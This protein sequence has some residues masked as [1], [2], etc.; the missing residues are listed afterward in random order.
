M[1]VRI[2]VPEGIPPGT[3]ELTPTPDTP[4]I[5]D[6]DPGSGP[7]PPADP[8][9]AWSDTVTVTCDG[10]EATLSWDAFPGASSYLASRDG[11][12]DLGHGPWQTTLTGD[13]RQVTFT[14]LVPGRTYTLTVTTDNGLP[15]SRTITL[16]AAETQPADD[17][18]VPG[19][20][21]SGLMLGSSGPQGRSIFEWERQLTSGRIA[22]ASTWSDS[23]DAAHDASSLAADDYLP[24]R[25]DRPIDIAVGGVWTSHGDTW[26]KAADGGL[27]GSWTQILEAVKRRWGGR[28]YTDLY[29]RFCHECNGHW[30]E[31][32]VREQD[33]DAYKRAFR[34][35]AALQRQILPGSHV[36]WPLND[37]TTVGFDF[38]RAYP[39]DAAVDVISVDQYNHYPWVNDINAF[40]AKMASTKDG[41]PRGLEAWR[42]Y[43]ASVGKPL[44][45]S[46]WSNDANSGDS[47]LYV[48]L[49][50][51]WLIEHGGGGP[52]QVLYA[53]LFNL[54]PQYQ[55]WPA[56]RHPAAS[57]AYRKLF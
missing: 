55:M 3:Y 52:G 33:I 51:K 50:H 34:R 53:C 36:L 21:P 30:Y 37:D 13:T 29:I 19:P 35:W 49:M 10:T 28:R 14:R 44:C 54:W 8:T 45:I 40:D 47:V 39:G 4:P 15:A 2:T 18:G 42:L 17:P 7:E 38:R 26:A 24:R 11:T 57:A 1:V 9:T 31:W 43:A 5:P 22:I 12:D 27:V 23:W 16:P 25:W 32:K 6:P 48:E 56:T 46:E 20:L 41:T